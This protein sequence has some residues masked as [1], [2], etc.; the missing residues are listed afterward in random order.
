[1]TGVEQ[2]RGRI[3][4]AHLGRPRIGPTDRAGVRPCPGSRRRRRSPG[5]LRTRPR[6]QQQGPD[7]R[8]AA[9]SRV[10][11][12]GQ[13]HRQ[14]ETQNRLLLDR[15]L[16]GEWVGLTLGD[17]EGG[18]PHRGGSLAGGSR[19]R[20]VAGQTRRGAD[21]RGTAGGRPRGRQHGD[22]RGRRPRRLPAIRSV[23]MCRV[24]QR[25]DADAADL[26][27]RSL[28]VRDRRRRACCGD[29]GTL[30]PAALVCH[31]GDDDVREHD[32]LAGS[33]AAGVVRVDA[34]VQR[35]SGRRSFTPR[36]G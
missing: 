24:V 19:L 34:Q 21:A 33:R 10:G 36:L 7:P 11:H 14:E 16:G 9:E 20:L 29:A 12:G 32:A 31:A 18:S 35:L 26:R 15:R 30:T 1:M 28:G 13:T 4:D 25:H 23:R 22:R 8:G 6:P 5:P 27:R 17:C 3:R 2:H